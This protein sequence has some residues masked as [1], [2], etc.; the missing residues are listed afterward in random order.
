MIYRIIGTILSVPKFF[1]GIFSVH[2]LKKLLSVTLSFLML[3][4]ISYTFIET[5]DPE[6]AFAASW[7]CLDS[8]GRP[9]A[10][11]T[12]YDS[13]NLNVSFPARP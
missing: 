13:G 2:T 4:T 5:V 6:P 3:L 1:R 12:K 11:Q 8:S 10:F 9:I 7:D